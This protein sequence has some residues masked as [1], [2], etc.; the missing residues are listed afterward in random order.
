MTARLSYPSFKGAFKSFEVSAYTN[1]E[2]GTD[3]RLHVFSQGNRD[4]VLEYLWLKF[5]W[6]EL[7]R[8]EYELFIICPETLNSDMKIGALRA[9]LIIG[10]KKV[11]NRL[12]EC[13][14]LEE[15][16]RPSRIR[17]QGF[18]RLDVEISRISRS[19]PK[20][21]KFSG[22]VKS[23]SSIGSKRRPGGPSFLEPLAIIEND[24]EDVIFNWYSYLTVDE[25][26]LLPSR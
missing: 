20:V 14:F 26:S 21:P 2:K 18:K 15:S 11:R 12:C 22:W 4:K 8:I 19:L 10:K 23:A 17:Y 16:K 3:S 5:L 24:Y 1:R 9:S 7:A 25:F 13:P 6:D